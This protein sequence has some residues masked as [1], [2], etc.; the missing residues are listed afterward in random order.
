MIHEFDMV[1]LKTPIP[2]R[3][4]PAGLEGTVVDAVHSKDG[5]VTVEFFKGEETIAVLPVEI[6]NLHPGRPGKFKNHEDPPRMAAFILEDDVVHI[7]A[8]EWSSDRSRLFEHAVRVRTYPAMELRRDGLERIPTP[9]F[10]LTFDNDRSVAVTLKNMDSPRFGV[11]LATRAD[12]SIVA[13]DI[14]RTVSTAQFHNLSAEGLAKVVREAAEMA[15]LHE[16]L[17]ED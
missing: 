11:Y 2:E 17:P 5:W 14:E 16:T 9:M 10:T 8:W 4:L 1:T 15:P 13:G 12:A 7:P 6:E 3:H